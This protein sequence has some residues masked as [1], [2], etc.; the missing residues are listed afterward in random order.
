MQKVPIITFILQLCVEVLYV[1]L[2][3]HI[4]QSCFIILISFAVSVG[5]IFKCISE[6]F[7]CVSLFHFFFFFNGTCSVHPKIPSLL[8]SFKTFTCASQCFV[9][10][11]WIPVDFLLIT[12]C[13]SRLLPF[14]WASNCPVC[15]S[16]TLPFWNP[17]INAR[18]V[19]ASECFASVSWTLPCVPRHA[20]PPARRM[21]PRPLWFVLVTFW[22]AL[23]TPNT[24]L[25]RS[26]LYLWLLDW[27]LRLSFY[28]YP[29][30]QRVYLRFLDLS[31]RFI[32]CKFGNLDF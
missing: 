10:I 4:P 26:A 15:T 30:V 16:R 32:D 3:F 25:R 7:P 24:H 22:F 17:S 5:I 29:W 28:V 6:P 27:G 18:S 19:C 12:H 11:S 1:Y 2:I 8:R 9:C 31:L 23:A 13:P 20:S 14:P 21:R